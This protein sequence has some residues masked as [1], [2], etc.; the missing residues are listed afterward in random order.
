MYNNIENFDKKN[1]ICKWVLTINCILVFELFT[2]V[3]QKNI[4]N[5][6]NL[7]E[8]FMLLSLFIQSLLNS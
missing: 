8:Q 3:I 6:D 5:K 7:L 4:L 1:K 2:V